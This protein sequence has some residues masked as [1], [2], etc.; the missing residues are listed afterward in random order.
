M[1]GSKHCHP[2]AGWLE[3]LT[4]SYEKLITDIEVLQMVAEMPPPAA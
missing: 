1:A 2:R 4:V 3:G